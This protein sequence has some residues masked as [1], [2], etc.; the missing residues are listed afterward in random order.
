LNLSG[1][2][3]QVEVKKR[4]LVGS[5]SHVHTRWRLTYGEGADPCVGARR[6]QS[7][8]KDLALRGRILMLHGQPAFVTFLGRGFD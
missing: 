8:S 1:S 5:P 6:A 7:T 4:S 3:F 2:E